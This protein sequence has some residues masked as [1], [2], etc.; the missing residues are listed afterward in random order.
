MAVAGLL[1]AFYGQSSPPEIERVAVEPTSTELL[2]VQAAWAAADLRTQA[3]QRRAWPDGVMK[4]L[5]LVQLHANLGP[6]GRPRLGSRARIPARWVGSPGPA[7]V[8]PPTDPPCGH[9][10]HKHGLPTPR[11]RGDA[12]SSDYERNSSAAY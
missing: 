5:E 8:L 11:Y 6:K 12:R 4:P 7:V 3:H 1:A 9:R 2:E 10:S